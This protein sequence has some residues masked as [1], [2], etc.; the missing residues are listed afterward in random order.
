MLRFENWFNIKSYV[1]SPN[2]RE[3]GLI[4]KDFMKTFH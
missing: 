1:Q 2:Y 3:S 4:C